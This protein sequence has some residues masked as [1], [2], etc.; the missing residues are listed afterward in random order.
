MV[1]SAKAGSPPSE[2]LRL[3]ILRGGGGCSL[4]RI[5]GNARR[6]GVRLMTIASAAA[7]EADDAATSADG[8]DRYGAAG[9]R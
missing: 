4:L 5:T 8:L 7:I 3:G 6:T 9:G 1:H 2:A